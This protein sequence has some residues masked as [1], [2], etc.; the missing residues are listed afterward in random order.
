MKIVGTGCGP[1][2]LTRE[3]ILAIR[4]AEK[5]YGSER[6][7]AM[8]KEYIR[9]DCR[10]EEIRDYKNLGS[11]PRDSVV[12][13]TG[14]P[15]LAGLGNLSGDV[16]PG[17][18]SLQV[19]AAR[20]GVPLARISVVLAHGRDHGTACAETM[21]ELLRGKIVFLLADPGFEVT[22]LAESLVHGYRDTKI[23]VCED[24]GYPDEQIRIGSC[25][26]PPIP[27]S[28]LFSLLIGD[29]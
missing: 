4:G 18:S 29:F 22:G 24:L 28:I 9:S 25:R 23:A 13:S 16:I 15:M 21:K 12:L 19:T 5:I 2:M 10:V 26:E 11:L 8:V 6:A 3:A 1:G 17:I 20:L 7:I 27:G 14:D